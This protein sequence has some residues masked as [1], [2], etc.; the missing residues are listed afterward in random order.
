MMSSTA[1]Q[2]SDK[3]QPLS[4][5]GS[6]LDLFRD[7]LQAPL[8]LIV[9][10]TQLLL[11]GSSGQM[12]AAA[13]ALV[14][15]VCTVAQKQLQMIERM[16][17]ISDPETNWTLL[18]RKVIN[19]RP[20]FDGWHKKMTGLCNDR[21]SCRFSVDEA[22]PTHIIG[23][24]PCLNQIIFPIID[25][26]FQY[27][28]RGVVGCRVGALDD[29]WTVTVKDTGIGMKAEQRLSL[30]R[31]LKDA[32]PKYTVC[33]LDVVYTLCR[34]MGGSVGVES[35]VDM[36]STFTIKLPLRTPSTTIAEA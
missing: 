12:D 17:E 30:F 19:T 18:E 16:V 35:K 10:Y 32:D 9:G 14:W 25:N 2:M 5:P 27:S 26:A 28:V 20:F 34:L 24:A 4:K 31:D 13:R 22:F 1:V 6:V 8:C 33:S 11:S 15:Q 21:L 29:Q 7:E 3:K 36:G 23:D